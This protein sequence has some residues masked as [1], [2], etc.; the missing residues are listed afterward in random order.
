GGGGR[1]DFSASML[2]GDD[3]R[4]ASGS[5]RSPYLEAEKYSLPRRLLRNFVACPSFCLVVG[6]GDP[7][8]PY[9]A[10]W[11]GD[12]LHGRKYDLEGQDSEATQR[13]VTPRCIR[14]VQPRGHGVI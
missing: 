4:A 1:D 3:H 7:G 9:P 8:Q 12:G 10:A 14:L 6:R 2:S 13:S 11:D 5:G